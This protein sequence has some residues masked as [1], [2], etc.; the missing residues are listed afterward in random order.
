[1][2]VYINGEKFAEFKNFMWRIGDTYLLRI[3]GIDLV[4]NE[5]VKLDVVPFY[6]PV[7]QVSAKDGQL[8]FQVILNQK[9]VLTIL[10]QARYP[11]IHIGKYETE[12][13]YEE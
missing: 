7:F 9:T 1:M 3:I 12:I 8:I 5:K 4:S 11:Y 6:Q 2:K 13:K 10:F